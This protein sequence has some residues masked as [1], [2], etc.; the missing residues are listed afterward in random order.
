MKDGAFALAKAHYASSGDDIAS[1]IVERVHGWV[2]LFAVD[3]LVEQDWAR[4]CL[5]DIKAKKPSVT[6]K[7]YPDNVAGDLFS[8]DNPKKRRKCK[9]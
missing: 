3:N 1:S 9:E 7:M 4:E 6:T 8:E 2:M 5:G